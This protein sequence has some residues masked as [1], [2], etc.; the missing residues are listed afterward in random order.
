MATTKEQLLERIHRHDVKVSYKDTTSTIR[1]FD[2]T[3]K[4]GLA[5]EELPV[6]EKD[7]LEV[8]EALYRA[9][10]LEKETRHYGTDNEEHFGYTTR[11]SGDI[12]WVQINFNELPS[13]IFAT[14]TQ[15]RNEAFDFNKLI[16]STDGTNCVLNVEM[17]EEL[18][19]MFQCVIGFCTDFLDDR[20]IN[21]AHYFYV[22]PKNVADGKMWIVSAKEISYVLGDDIVKQDYFEI[23]DD[24]LTL[25]F[26]KISLSLFERDE[27]I[28]DNDEYKLVHFSEAIRRIMIDYFVPDKDNK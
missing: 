12:E 3:M 17:L 27:F 2:F 19:N 24:G 7:T 28:K 10:I 26:D 4:L 1:H 5:I 25:A 11:D 6:F 9:E 14:A 23:E 15:C 16:V 8:L 18:H 21:A 13:L 20:H 22:Y